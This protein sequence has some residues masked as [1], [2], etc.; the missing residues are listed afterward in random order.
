MVIKNK[1]L[2]VSNWLISRAIKK[3]RV[4]TTSPVPK[5]RESLSA[6]FHVG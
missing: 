6:G 1:Y 4:R 5:G 2:E 3:I